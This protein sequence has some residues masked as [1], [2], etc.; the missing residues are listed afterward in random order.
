MGMSTS[1]YIWLVATSS[2]E[3]AFVPTFGPGTMLIRSRGYTMTDSDGTFPWGGTMDSQWRGKLLDDNRQVNIVPP[4]N[5]TLDPVDPVD[6]EAPPPGVAPQS[7]AS[8]VSSSVQPSKPPL[9]RSFSSH[10]VVRDAY[11]DM[12]T[13]PDNIF[14][15]A[16]STDTR[17]RKLPD[18]F[19]APQ[20]KVSMLNSSD[21]L[22][23]LFCVS[24]FEHAWMSADYGIWGKE[25]WLK[26]LWTVLDWK[27]VSTNLQ[28]AK[29][30]QNRTMP[31]RQY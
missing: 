21:T 7:P 11:D 6:S 27:K 3:L 10:S 28:H 2:G 19:Q 24:L 29:T 8:G 17:P 23:P 18:N 12:R 31:P 25:D 9:S 5:R 26:E 4:N 15:E 16:V 22:Y 1:G 30:M 20:V 13:P 14:R